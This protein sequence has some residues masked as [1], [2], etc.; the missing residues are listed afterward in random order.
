MGKY[1]MGIDEGTTGCKTCLVDATGT[2][3]AI[4]AREYPCYYPR[5]GW[6]EQDID[7]IKNN[8]FNACKEA[9]VKSNIDPRDIV[10]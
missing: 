3:I 7:E 10:G 5:P 9:I 8:V 6:V 1:F 4:A 2:P